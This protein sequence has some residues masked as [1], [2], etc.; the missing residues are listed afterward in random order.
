MG[1]SC[2][3]GG[4]AQKTGFSMI[5]DR[6]STIEHVQQAL[7]QAKVEA[8]NLIFAVDLT[9]SNNDT[10]K[11]TFNDTSL[12]KIEDRRPNPYQQVMKFACKTLGPFDEDGLIPAFAFGDFQT[13]HRKVFNLNPYGQPCQG[14]DQVLKAY[15]ATIPHVKLS[16][17]TSFA[18]IIRHACEIVRQTGTYHILFIVT[19]GEVNDEGETEK[20]IVDAS[21]LAL[22]IV[23]VG[24]GDGPFDL[25]E[26]YDDHLPQRE[27]DN[28]QFVNYQKVLDK[29]MRKEVDVEV[30]FAVDAMQ[31]IP[32]HYAYL[33]KAGKL[34]RPGY[35]IGRFNSE[36]E[37]KINNDLIKKA[38][39][40]SLQAPASG[41]S[42]SNSTAEGTIATK[43]DTCSICLDR[44]ANSVIDQCGHTMCNHR[45]CVASARGFCPVCRKP[46]TKFIQIF[47][48]T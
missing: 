42:S 9:S 30:Q 48:S 1:N 20:A 22:S 40:E 14:F 19:D 7:R 32:D 38:F 15:N 45:D 5:P 4:Q 16:G 18:P 39:D 34:V 37:L 35:D 28:L 44:K 2:S 23:I 29:A 11:K 46:I 31:E 21:S 17:P 12:H 10:G 41:S 33:Q 13:K 27:C 26:K 24:V 43:E 3:N 25:M 6:H 8:V 47:H 36:W